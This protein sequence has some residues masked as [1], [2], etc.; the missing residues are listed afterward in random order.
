MKGLD[1]ANT[2]FD[3][4]LSKANPSHKSSVKGKKVLTQLRASQAK[5]VNAVGEVNSDLPHLAI[6]SYEQVF[7][8]ASVS[9][10]SY[11]GQKTGFTP[12]F[13]F[14]TEQQSEVGHM[15]SHDSRNGARRNQS[16]PDPCSERFQ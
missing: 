16:K 2:R 5:I 12:Q 6:I 7:H 8:D 9:H 1:H 15:S 3:V 13:Q 10:S 14:T 11:V 4:D